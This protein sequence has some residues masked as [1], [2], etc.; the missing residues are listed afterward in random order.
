[1]F[2]HLTS[3]RLPM[4]KILTRTVASVCVFSWMTWSVAVAV[5]SP[6]VQWHL[7]HCPQ[8]PLHHQSG[9][10]H[11]FGHCHAID[12]KTLFL[13]HGVMADVPIGFLPTGRH[14]VPVLRFRCIELVPRGPPAVAE[15][16]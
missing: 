12:S 10:G 14:T 11:C 4:A 1:M 8:K 16:K 2:S 13:R 7:S 5:G 15:I 9:Q 6:G 3:Y